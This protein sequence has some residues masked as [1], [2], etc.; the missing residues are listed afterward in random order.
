M[1]AAGTWHAAANADFRLAGR[2]NQLPL[3]PSFDRYRN[4]SILG[5]PENAASRI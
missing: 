2:V 1:V 4:C 3:T 5:S